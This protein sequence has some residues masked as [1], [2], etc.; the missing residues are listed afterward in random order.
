MRSEASI[1]VDPRAVT[2]VPQ[3]PA[4]RPPLPQSPL[5]QPS[6]VQTQPAHPQF[7]QPPVQTQPPPPRR[8]SQPGPYV[9]LPADKSGFEAFMREQ[10]RAN[11]A[12]GSRLNWNQQETLLIPKDDIGSGPRA[13]LDAKNVRWAFAGAGLVAVIVGAI[14]VFHG[15]PIQSVKLKPAI[16]VIAT[17]PSGAE[18]VQGGAVLG[19]TPMEVPRPSAGFSEFSV[20]M[21][22]FQPETVRLSPQSKE[23]I[24]LTLTPAAP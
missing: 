15:T 3:A 16:T 20:R 8:F 24:R 21:A 23:A 2:P 14:S 7:A 10:A 17:E 5:A 12:T 19:N 1:V 13:V 22:G 6:F 9:P 4:S 18:L 11:G